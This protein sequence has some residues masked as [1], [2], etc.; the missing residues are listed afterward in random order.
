M[1]KRNNVTKKRNQQIWNTIALFSAWL[2]ILWN[3]ETAFALQ[4]QFNPAADVEAGVRN[5]T[6]KWTTDQNATGRINYAPEQPLASNKVDNALVTNHTFLLLSL[7]ANRKYLFEILSNNG[8][9]S[10]RLPADPAQFFEF[11]TLIAP[12]STPPGPITA[13]S[14]SDLKAREVTITWDKTPTDSDIAG[15]DI[16]Q[17]D[18]PIKLNHTEKKYTAA[19]LK[20][21]AKYTF[22]VRALDA[23]GNQGPFTSIEITTKVDT[24]REIIIT[25]VTADAIGQTALIH[26]KTNF[27]SHSRVEY[28]KSG[29]LLENKQENPAMVKD[30]N[31]TLGNLEKNQN[32]TYRAISCDEYA[33]CQNSSEFTFETV[34]REELFLEIDK[35]KCGETKPFLHNSNQLD[36]G[37]RTIAKADVTADVNGA[38]KR[39]KRTGNDGAFVFN[40][41]DLDANSPQNIIK[42]TADDR[43]SKKI[44]CERVIKLDYLAPEVQLKNVTPFTQQ[45]SIELSGNVSDDSDIFVKV[46]LTSGS[47]TQ[48]PAKVANLVNKSL[49]A[50]ALN[51]KWDKLTDEDFDLYLIYRDDVTGGPVDYTK[52]SEWTDEQISPG[53]VYTYRVSGVDRAGN[54]GERSNGL[55]LRI[56]G[57]AKESSATPTGATTALSKEVAK[58]AE[59]T[60]QNK[61]TGK[62]TAK[63]RTVKKDIPTKALVV[64]EK[65]PA[66]GVNQSAA[67]KHAVQPLYEGVNNIRTVFSDEAGNIFEQTF[68]V[69]RDSKAPKIISPTSAQL[70]QYYSPSYVSEIEIGGQVDDPT[71]SVWVFVN[72]ESQ[73]SAAPQKKVK[74]GPNGTFTITV[75]LEKKIAG[76]A[77]A[78]G[79]QATVGIGSDGVSTS[80]P[81]PTEGPVPGSAGGQQGA[82]GGLVASGSFEN[83]VRLVAVDPA[84]QKSEPVEGK[85]RLTACGEGNVIYTKLDIPG[86]I[87]NT[88]EIIQGLASF[89]LKFE[90]DW[91]GAGSCTNCMQ[92][93]RVVSPPLSQKEAKRYDNDWVQL[94]ATVTANIN[95]TQGFILLN[96]KQQDPPGK[97]MY[98]KENWLSTHRKDECWPGNALGCIHLLLMMEQPYINPLPTTPPPGGVPSLVTP[99]FT[100]PGIQKKCIDIKIM[101]DARSDPSVIPKEFLKSMITAINETINFI[102]LI[103]G[104]IK[105]I[106]LIT[107]GLCLLSWVAQFFV[108]VNAQFQCKFASVSGGSASVTDFIKTLRQRIDIERIAKFGGCDVEFVPPDGAKEEEKQGYEA[109]RS[110]CNTCASAISTKKD[111]KYAFHFVCDRIMCP[112]VPTLQYYIKQHYRSGGRPTMLA[113]YDCPT[114]ENDYWDQ[115]TSCVCKAGGPAPQTSATTPG[116]PPTSGGTK[117]ATPSPSGAAVFDAAQEFD[118]TSEFDGTSE[119]DATAETSENAALMTYYNAPMTGYQVADAQSAVGTAKQTTGNRCI[120]GQ[121]CRNG[122]CEDAKN[123]NDLPSALNR[124]PCKCGRDLCRDGSQ[125]CVGTGTTARCS[126]MRNTGV[127]GCQ[128]NAPARVK[129]YCGAGL[130]ACEAGQTCSNPQGAAPSCSDAKSSTTTG[131]AVL[132][133]NKSSDDKSSAAGGDSGGQPYG[134]G[135]EP[136]KTVEPQ[137]VD[138]RTLEPLMAQETA[139]QETSMTAMPTSNTITGA[140]VAL[141]A[142]STPPQE[143]T[144]TPVGGTKTPGVTDRS[145]MTIQQLPPFYYQFREY[146]KNKY[147]YKTPARMRE[148]QSDCELVEIGRD[149]LGKMFRAYEG[150]PPT[151]R[152]SADESN[153]ESP[154]VNLAE[155]CGQPHAPQAACCPFEYMQEWGL[156]AIFLNEM[157]F[158]HCLANPDDDENCGFGTAVVRGIT[159][160]CDPQSGALKTFVELDGIQYAVNQP[161]RDA[162]MFNSNVVYF[163]ELDASGSALKVL[164]GYNGRAASL[165]TVTTGQTFAEGTIP[166][167][168]TVAFIPLDIDQ[169]LANDFPQR[170]NSNLN[171]DKDRVSRLQQTDWF[172]DLCNAIQSNVV[173][174]RGQGALTCDPKR[175]ELWWRQIAGLMGDPG[176]QYIVRPAGSMI[177]SLITLCLTGILSWLANF[178][179]ML[180]LLMQCFQAILVTGDGSAGQCQSIIS[181]YICDIIYEAISCFVKRMGGPDGAQIGEGGIGGFFGAVSAAGR[182]VDSDAKSRYGDTNFFATQFTTEKLVHDVCVFA[183]TGE[184]PTDWSA[185]LESQVTLPTASSAWVFPATRRWQSYDATS[186]SGGL[187]VG[188]GQATYVY[189]IAYS[190]NAGADINFQLKLV[191]SP[192]DCPEG[193]DGKCDCA[194]APPASYIA[195]GVTPFTGDVYDRVIPAH[196]DDRSGNCP[197]NGFLKQ[198]K[199]CSEDILVKVSSPVRFDKAVLS[200]TFVGAGKGGQSAVPGATVVGSGNYYS[201]NVADPSALNGF[202]EAVLRELGGPPLGLCDFN[203][204]KLSFLCGIEL[205][206]SGVARFVGPPQLFRTDAYV[207]GES[208]IASLRVEVQ[209]PKDA[210][211]CTV[212]CNYTKYLVLKQVLNGRGGRVYPKGNNPPLAYERLTENRLKEFIFFDRNDLAGHSSVFGDFKITAEDFSVTTGGAGAA[213]AGSKE[214]TVESL[215]IKIT[216]E[217]DCDAASGQEAHIEVTDAVKDGKEAA[218]KDVSVESAFWYKFTERIGASGQFTPTGEYRPC[219]AALGTGGDTQVDC[220]GMK[221]FVSKAYLEDPKKTRTKVNKLRI[222]LKREGAGA[223]GGFACTDQVEKWKAFFEIRDARDEGGIFTVATMPSIDPQTGKPQTAVVEFPVVCKG[224][225]PK[226]A[227]ARTIVDLSPGSGITAAKVGPDNTQQNPSFGMWSEPGAL[228]P[229][230][231]I[232]VSNFRWTNSFKKEEGFTIN[233]ETGATEAALYIDLRPLGIEASEQF[234]V[235]KNQKPLQAYVGCAAPCVQKTPTDGILILRLRRGDPQFKFT[236]FKQGAKLDDYRTC[237]ATN[238]CVFTREKPADKKVKITF[239][240]GNDPITVTISNYVE[241]TD[242]FDIDYKTT[243][244][245]LLDPVTIAFNVKDVFGT[246][247]LKGGLAEIGVEEI[248]PCVTGEATGKISPTGPSAFSYLGSSYEVAANTGKLV[249][250]DGKDGELLRLAS[251]GSD[252]RWFKSDGTLAPNSIIHL[253]AATNP[254]EFANKY[255]KLDSDSKSIKGS[256]KDTFA[257]ASKVTGMLVLATKNEETKENEETKDEEAANRAVSNLAAPNLITGLAA[258]DEYACSPPCSGDAKC[259]SGVCISD[260]DLKGFKAPLLSGKLP[261]DQNR[262][263]GVSTTE[264]GIQT[265]GSAGETINIRKLVKQE[266]FAK[267]KSIKDI[268]TACITLN[269]AQLSANGITVNDAGAA[270]KLSEGRT[271]KVCNYRPEKNGFLVDMIYDYYPAPG[272]APDPTIFL[273][274]NLLVSNWDAKGANI[275]VAGIGAL[276]NCLKTEVIESEDFTQ[277]AIRPPQC[278]HGRSKEGVGL[279]LVPFSTTTFRFRGLKTSKSVCNAA[280]QDGIPCETPDEQYKSCWTPPDGTRGCYSLCYQQYQATAIK[281]DESGFCINTQNEQCLDAE[282]GVPLK[283][284]KLVKSKCQGGAQVLCCTTGIKKTKPKALLKFELM[285]KG[286]IVEGDFGEVECR[287]KVPADFSADSERRGDAAM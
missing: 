101:I 254:Q 187:G 244:D 66:T 230:E 196:I 100:A 253:D 205:P 206:S 234:Q 124:P 129:C 224:G 218:G 286:L 193:K 229:G 245:K 40:G 91:Q 226:G 257:D 284:D 152:F 166:R 233:I 65:I 185:L 160:I 199:I 73:N 214:C 113:D 159:G 182:E 99:E 183:F 21:S 20:G 190:L 213:T 9:Q 192:K 222:H 111:V 264:V 127:P 68:T 204:G 96:I 173:V 93:P 255:C 122:K 86:S 39:Y 225:L 126:Q 150:L 82:Y 251:A 63:P 145:F 83:L 85:I 17:N 37:G 2:I 10:V 54:E 89:G 142:P 200:W 249:G 104:P 118:A 151:A 109:L 197:A 164:R 61:L 153:Q 125:T 41:I 177:Q 201:K 203:L 154:T 276:P 171:N 228:A 43:V 23:A 102:N 4:L 131:S 108:A 275:D 88:R 77:A 11:T 181:Q 117:P 272:S 239:T 149:P 250:S 79:T 130:V 175:M 71:A 274:I 24:E 178:R 136:H 75:N 241:K 30:H 47:D 56:P 269:S 33:N 12:D 143:G 210:A 238:P 189:R 265:R 18:E 223:A 270:E 287:L 207:P 134:A 163:I 16:Y 217:P 231:E 158:S 50:A 148:V 112:A 46:Y 44:D 267:E 169:N 138:S 92:K 115:E 52:D 35:F 216:G 277:S 282:K 94:P 110:A 215:G 95:N 106:T 55:R 64:D 219:A 167:D 278:I 84:Q 235:I 103:Y 258:G 97:T 57:P 191:C 260:K 87:L 13:L 155:K 281:K 285:C 259:Y 28:A 146:E 78:G 80:T 70:V 221:F 116:Q 132:S 74:V 268:G 262:C 168:G 128:Q 6:I 14:I 7:T 246:D 194:H 8:T 49:S 209:Q 232:I 161:T 279:Y 170:D 1:K 107:I 114:G 186:L 243:P 208:K 174:T 45:S 137:R 236:G 69:L 98:E 157:R 247:P 184:W 212:D 26:W 139:E 15:Y 256:C 237:T 156:G 22:K 62:A 198:G 140:Q 51:L 123:C 179:N 261:A 188:Q 42:V 242:G 180:G 5:A 202:S 48:G 248:L 211:S 38:R 29:L 19:G 220:G 165:S 162:F 72:P 27:P 133:L 36:I 176:R 59:K 34:E 240:P 58:A 280:P 76:T 32:Y 3:V 144:A 105:T 141:P 266:Q 147:D 135:E 90:N 271:I 31:T 120:K 60:Q 53:A 252:S 263:E 67:F 227:A 283:E 25:D 195:S 172:N 273:D 81:P 119:F 121:R